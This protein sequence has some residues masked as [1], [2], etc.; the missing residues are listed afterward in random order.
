MWKD[1]ISIT[2]VL[3]NLLNEADASHLIDVVDCWVQK[4]REPEK[5]ITRRLHYIVTVALPEALVYGISQVNVNV[6]HIFGII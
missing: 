4:F 6:N 1:V 2:D 3:G 5:S